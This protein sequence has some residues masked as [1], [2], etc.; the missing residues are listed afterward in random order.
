MNVD[1]VRR[2]LSFISAVSPSQRITADTPDAWLQL[3]HDVNYDDAYAAARRIAKRSVYVNVADIVA[4]TR[5]TRAMPKRGEW[6]ECPEHPGQW[7]VSC[8]C[9]RAD[10]LVG[11]SA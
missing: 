8:S 1:E 6:G 7:L 3:L 9:C 4:E 2:L 11:E 10:R 5:A